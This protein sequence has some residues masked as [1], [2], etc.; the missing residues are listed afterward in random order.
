MAPRS[1]PPGG[2]A[3]CCLAAAAIAAYCSATWVKLPELV[4]S[5]MALLP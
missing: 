4:V 2:A 3:F 1:S 5:V